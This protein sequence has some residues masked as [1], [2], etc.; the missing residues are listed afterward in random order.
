MAHIPGHGIR[1]DI[2][3]KA[4]KERGGSSQLTS[5][6]E[7]ITLLD[8]RIEGLSEPSAAAPGFRIWATCPGENRMYR[9]DDRFAAQVE[10][11]IYC[12]VSDDVINP[13][14]WQAGGNFAYSTDKRFQAISAYPLPIYDLKA[15][16]AGKKA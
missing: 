16:G 4:G 2:F 14:G 9:A 7:H 12:L 13:R 5:T 11:A 1:L 10:D 3:R 6:V 8:T 15:N